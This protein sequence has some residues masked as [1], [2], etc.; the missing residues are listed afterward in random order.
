[1]GPSEA[2]S[3]SHIQIKGRSRATSAEGGGGVGMQLQLTLASAVVDLDLHEPPGTGRIT[4]TDPRQVFWLLGQ[5]S[6]DGRQEGGKAFG[7]GW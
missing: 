1:M 5:R 2:R 4:C 7:G 6:R 3:R